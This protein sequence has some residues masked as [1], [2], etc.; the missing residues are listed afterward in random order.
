MTSEDEFEAYMDHLF[1]S[2][3]PGK[4]LIL[5]VADAVPTDA[6]FERLVRIGERV[7]KEGRLPLKRRA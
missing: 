1:E 3:T 4:R 7:E 5:G 2:V 6:V